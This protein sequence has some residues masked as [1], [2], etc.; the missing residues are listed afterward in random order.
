LRDTREKSAEE[1]RTERE[2]FHNTMVVGLAKKARKD[3]SFPC[4]FV[5]LGQDK[6]GPLAETRILLL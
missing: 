6:D 3:R 4:P 5:S 1:R 2:E